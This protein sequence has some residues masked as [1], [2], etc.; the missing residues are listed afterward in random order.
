MTLPSH[1]W[2]H[3]RKSVNPYIREIPAY[4]SLLQLSYNTPA[5]ETADNRQMDKENV[6]HI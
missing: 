3:I 5:V 4:P 6:V 2:A 1:S